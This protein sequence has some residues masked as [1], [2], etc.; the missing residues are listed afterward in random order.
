MENIFKITYQNTEGIVK[1]LNLTFI[2]RIV[3]KIF[4]IIPEVK[5]IYTLKI[6]LDA[7][8]HISDFLIS[9][10]GILWGILNIDK[11]KYI[12]ITNISPI[13]YHEIRLGSDLMP[14]YSCYHRPAIK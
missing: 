14:T 1:V 7:P 2:Q 13:L 4:K 5:W 10:D 8:I 3:C 6:K 9:S 12:T 11:D